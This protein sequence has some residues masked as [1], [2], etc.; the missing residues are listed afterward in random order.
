[1]TLTWRS[2]VWSVML[3]SNDPQVGVD[4]DTESHGQIDTHFIF[5]FFCPLPTEPIYINRDYHI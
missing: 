5:K 1:M 2:N 4:L 3:N